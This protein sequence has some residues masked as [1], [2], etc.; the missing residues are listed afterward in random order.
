[1]EIAYNIFINCFELIFL[2][3]LMDLDCVS[4]ATSRPYDVDQ[5]I[6]ISI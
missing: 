4:S 1:M 6:Q 2:S 5:M 3:S